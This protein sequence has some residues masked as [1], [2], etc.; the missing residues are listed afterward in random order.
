MDS[1]VAG[2]MNAAKLLGMDKSIGSLQ[3]G[4]IAD[5]VAVPG[6]PLRDIKRMQETVFVM[7]NGAVYK[8]R[9]VMP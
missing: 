6:D 8:E 1:I 7:K 4:K 2:T 5:I 9:A 3:T